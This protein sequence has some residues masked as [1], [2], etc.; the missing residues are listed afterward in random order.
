M[1]GWP[2]PA[3]RHELGSF[4]ALAGPEDVQRF[5]ELAPDDL[6]WA[7]SH[8][9]D[10]RLGAAALL[11]SVRWLG[12]VPDALG[13]LPRPALLA[14]CE[15]LEADPDDLVVYGV[16]P[17]TRSDHLAAARARAGFL[18]CDHE[19]RAPFEEWLALRAMEHERPKALWELSCEHLLAVKV[20]RP[21]VDALVRMIAAARE[22]A[23]TATAQLLAEQL[24]GGRA[25][26]LDRLLELREPGGITWLEW[27]RRPAAGSSPAEILTALAKL[28][29]LR[30]LGGERV[31]LSMLAPGR[32]RMLAAEG[33]RRAAWEISRLPATRRHPLL[34]VFVAQMFI[35]R[36]DELIDRYCTAIQTVERTASQ[37]VK[38]QREATARQRD[39]RSQL[40]GLLSQILL[41]AIDNGEDPVA[42]ARAEIGE[43]RLRACVEDPEALASPIDAQRR[44]AKHRRHAHLARFAPAVLTAL[45]LRAARGYE[46]LLEAIRYSAAHRDEPRLPDAPLSVLP[47][48]WRDWTLDE[49]GIPVRTR[50]ELALW[51]KARDALRARGL[52]RAGSHRYGDPADWMMPRLQWRRERAELAEL[53]DRPLD[54][55]QRLAA[56]EGR[57]RELARALQEG[58]ER[59]ERV[60]FDGQRLTGEPA[61]ERHVDESPVARLVSGM[62]PPVQYASLLVDVHRDTGFLDELQH[63]GQGA[64]SPARQGQLVAA[65]LADIFGVGYARMA[66]ACA[67][68]EREMREAAS[69]HFTAENLDAA[70]AVVVQKL[71]LLPHEWIAEL[72]LTSSDGTRLETIGKSPIG[73]YAARHA[74][75]RRRVLTWLLWLTGEYGHFGGKVIPVNEPESWHTLDALMHLDTP[76]V[77][78]T[79]DT[80]GTTELTFAV[81]DLLGWE[82]Y[83]RLADLTERRLYLLGQPGPLIAAEQLLTHRIR[84]E[85]I[86]EQWDELLRIAGSIKRGWIVPSVL[87]SRMATDPKPDRTARAL[88]E[89]GRL[90]ETNFILRWAGDPPLR[91]RSHAQLNKGENANALRRALGYGNRGR[92]RAR[93]PEQLH[94]Q[95]EARR[96]GANAIHY[97]NTRYIA[98]SLGHLA[99]FGID[100]PDGPISGVHNAH[101]EHI[102]LIGH[103]HINLRAGPRHGNHRRLRLPAEFDTLRAPG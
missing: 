13:E 80:H 25:G 64:R 59:G 18:A 6:R 82:F 28:E 4:P 62:L 92:V 43:Q 75:Y 70:N 84:A 90:I 63:Y 79:T 69:R 56:L 81:S 45:D 10:A 1:A 39:E 72:L 100:L 33:R 61:G 22:R 38:D 30:L 77:Q 3:Q 76:T 53:F 16:R 93:D 101:H 7:L 78:H 36:G 57:Q 50:Y 34:L 94:R 17:Q 49:D 58:Y 41:D 48:G 46:P 67:Y 83:P 74:G 88:G 103:H 66:L 14:L 99:R 37:A 86:L 97:W 12:F 20:V 60:L 87:I 91:Q 23:H 32:V 52:Y 29:Q 42:R 89:Y 9:G 8:R 71:R 35:E 95:L 44:D 19:E 47:A 40:A 68:S 21:P 85:L 54:G 5:F 2:S 55:A 31:D 51:I 27:L 73:A 102:N 11:C 96:L 15:Q 98:L 65:L 26:R 24:A